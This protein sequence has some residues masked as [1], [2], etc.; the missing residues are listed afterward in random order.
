[1]N[2]SNQLVENIIRKV[3]GEETLPLYRALRNKIN[4]SEFLLAIKLKEEINVVRNK[5][6]RL[7]HANLVSFTRKKDKQKGWYIYYW[8]FNNRRIK[9]LTSHLKRELFEKLTEQA[10]KEK[11]SHFF[12][13]HS[14]CMRLTFDRAVD[15][16]YKCPECGGLM[17]QVDNAEKIR[18]LEQEIELLRR[19]IEKKKPALAKTEKKEKRDVGAPKKKLK[20]KRR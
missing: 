16:N 17:E 14:K 2:P 19:E 8:T 12:M 20:K 1:M 4:V 6:Y 9:F 10:R 11:S 13:C 5:L 7:Y 15:F 3:A 18:G